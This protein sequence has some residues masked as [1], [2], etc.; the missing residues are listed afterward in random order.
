MRAIPLRPDCLILAR[1][2]HAFAAADAPAAG[3]ALSAG[4]I[5]AVG[6]RRA[7]E[8]LRGRGTQ[9]HDLGAAVLTPGLVDCH[10]H[11]FSWALSR[12]LAVDLSASHSLDDMQRRMARA[13]RGAPDTWVLGQGFDYNRWGDA[14]PTAAD[15][16]RAISTRPVLI[17]SRDGHT[18]VLN[19]A[20]LRRAGISAR[21]ADP[22]GGRFLRDEHGEPTGVVQ[23]AA[24][25]RLP[26]PL[27][28]FALRT[29]AAAGAKVAR[30]LIEA[31]ATAHSHG[32]TGVH[33]MDDGV[34]LSHMQRLR[35]A[36]GLTLRVVHAVQR[37]DWPAA[38]QVGLRSGL[39][40][41]WL[42]I[43][44]LKIFSDGSLG[45]QSAYM[46]EPYPG[47]G[48]YCGVP[49]V[50]GDELR[51]LACEAARH[52]WAVW[53]H[54]IGD[55]AVHEAVEAICAARRAGTPALPH[56][57]EHVQCARPADIR[58]MARAGI[59]A[60]VQ[61]CHILGDIATARRHWPTAQ[62]HAYPLRTLLDAG[63]TLAAGSDVP[64]E[65][66]DPRRS[67]LAAT[68]RSDETGEPRGGWFPKQRLTARE[69][70]L[71]FTRGA[72]DAGGAPA[73][74]GTL[75]PGAPAD[76]TIWEDDPLAVPATE[77]G[78]IGIL[79]C[80]VGGRIHLP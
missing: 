12:A 10:T 73:G 35:A 4:R 15:L 67:L 21:T 65:S 25:E 79:G 30:A 48:D 63:V 58:R 34:S 64:I 54:A 76:I 60:S 47:R 59:I 40:D 62:R 6:P 66:L 55:R 32:I 45:S 72:A 22:P 71:A 5:L 41:D 68:T 74:A 56:R 78:R 37:A 8:R 77:L 3:V 75:T 14:P 27:R 53:V 29:D 18:A 49:V 26:D 42:R 39:G 51:A 31:A 52:G 33:S 9:V 2:V 19:T 16:D 11:F 13:A 20:G 70:L 43:G 36:G 1:R 7:I 28:E 57:I 24:L 17:R 80:V 23:E 61:P 69:T 46:F 44:G 38:R 50:A